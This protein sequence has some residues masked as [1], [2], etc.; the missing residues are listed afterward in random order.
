MKIVKISEEEEEGKYIKLVVTP[1]KN[2][3]SVKKLLIVSFEE[4]EIP[5]DV[6]NDQIILRSS[7]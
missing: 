1:L 7:F 2:L 6:E 3:E 5:K 4:T